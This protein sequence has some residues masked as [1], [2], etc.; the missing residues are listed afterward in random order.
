MMI[1]IIIIIII[2]III[3]IIIMIILSFDIAPFPYK[4]ATY[5]ARGLNLSI[6]FIRQLVKRYD[7]VCLSEHWLHTNR[8]NRL[9]EVDTDIEYC[10]RSSWF[11]DSDNYGT[12]R[13]QGGVALIWKKSLGGVSEYKDIINDRV[14]GIRIQNAKGAVFNI[15]SVY[16]SSNGSPESFEAALED[17]ADI[18]ESREVGSHSIVAGDLNADM[19]NLT[20]NRKAC[21][22]IKG[23]QSLHKFIETYI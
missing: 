14:C 20:G 2:K 8:Q 11:S 23:G 1:M 12:Q 6:P 10:A 21:N 9:D 4:H 17:L 19:A 5:N 16:M 3:I 13:G 18:I 15:F 22:A 7:V